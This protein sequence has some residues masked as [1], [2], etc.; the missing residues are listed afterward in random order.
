MI[1]FVLYLKICKYF[2]TF[3]CS[4]SDKFIK[5]KYQLYLT[6]IITYVYESELMW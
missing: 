3:L 6:I 1:I 4:F 5:G 2:G